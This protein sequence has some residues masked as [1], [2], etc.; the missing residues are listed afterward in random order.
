MLY[1]KIYKKEFKMKDILIVN[2]IFYSLQGESTYAGK[3]CIFIRLT[4]CPLN[5]VWCDTL[6]AKNEGIELSVGEILETIRNW[7]CKLVEIT[8]G[9]PLMQR[10]TF[11]LMK[12]L[13]KLNYEVMLETSGAFSI[14]EVPDGVKIIM[15]IKCPSS[16]EA[17]KNLWD[18][19]RFL[20]DT[21]EI[22]FVI[23]DINDYNWAKNIL[24]EKLSKL[25]CQILFSPV[26]GRLEIKILA[27]WILKDMLP[28]RLQIPLHKIIWGDIRGV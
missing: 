9:E 27:E 16:G 14:R 2:E 6:Y 22:K 12:E 3:R 24:K 23:A 1:D 26:W 13:L 4:G 5:C 10:S 20:K 19:I 25:K 17:E 28:V 8:G 21:D 11:N 18:N 7:D 15:D